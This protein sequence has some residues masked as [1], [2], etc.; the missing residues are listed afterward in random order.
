MSDDTKKTIY[1]TVGLVAALVVLGLI[2]VQT[3]WIAPAPPA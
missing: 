1:W 2:A 3:G